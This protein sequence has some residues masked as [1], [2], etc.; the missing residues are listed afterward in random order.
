M[1]FRTGHLRSP[2]TLF[3]GYIM[4]TPHAPAAAALLFPQFSPLKKKKKMLPSLYNSRH[5]LD[6]YLDELQGGVTYIATVKEMLDQAENDWPTMLARLRRVR[7]TLLSKKQ[8][9][10]NLTGDQVWLWLWFAFIGLV[11]FG[12][13][14]F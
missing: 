1:S 3:D 14:W 4:A 11:W 6:G 12:L 10:L 2:G 7:A 9:L 13:V 5:T 8:F